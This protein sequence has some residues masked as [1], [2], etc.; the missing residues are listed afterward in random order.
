MGIHGF[1]EIV[2]NLANGDVI[3]Y[4]Q[5]DEKVARSILQ[6]IKPARLFSDKQLLIAGSFTM[7]GFATDAVERVDFVMEGFPK[8]PHPGHIREF[9]ELSKEEFNEQYNA[10]GTGEQIR[11]SAKDQFNHLPIATN[12]KQKRQEKYKSPMTKTHPFSTC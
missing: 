10:M 4:K 7:S 1:L 12:P 3:T 11:E 6:A 5:E 9:A 2:V 8:W